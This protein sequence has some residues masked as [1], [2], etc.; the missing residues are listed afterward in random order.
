MDA[1]NGEVL[2]LAS[3]GTTGGAATKTVSKTDMTLDKSVDKNLT[4]LV[5]KA[6]KK[7][8]VAGEKKS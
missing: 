7:L 8:P 1:K 3:L 5:S 2:A 4:K 6:L